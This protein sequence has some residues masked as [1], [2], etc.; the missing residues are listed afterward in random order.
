VL[1]GMRDPPRHP[2]RRGGGGR[3]GFTGGE[4]SGMG[5]AP[6]QASVQ[7]FLSF[8]QPKWLV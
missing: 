4:R 3:S 7:S 2:I 1:D 8:S 5:K 6:A